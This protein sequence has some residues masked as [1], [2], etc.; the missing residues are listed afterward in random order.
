MRLIGGGAAGS[1]FDM[2]VASNEYQV[3]ARQEWWKWPRADARNL[4]A[5]RAGLNQVDQ[6][7]LSQG[8]S[9]TEWHGQSGGP[10]SG[11][12][13]VRFRVSPFGPVQRA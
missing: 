13:P 9:E 4:A 6:S 7:Q 11:T 3:F 2:L 10:E 5:E 1:A 12:R 8:S